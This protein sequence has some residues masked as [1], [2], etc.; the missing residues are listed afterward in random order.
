V[1]WTFVEQQKC[2][3]DRSAT[4][5]S[6]PAAASALAAATSAAAS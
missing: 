1:H 5:G 4:A 6:M 2:C 3:F